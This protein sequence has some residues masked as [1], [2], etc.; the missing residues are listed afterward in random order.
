MYLL[1]FIRLCA[2]LE[3]R[4]ILIGIWH[5]KLQTLE[6]FC[7]SSFMNIFFKF[8]FDRFFWKCEGFCKGCF[9]KWY[10]NDCLALEHDKEYLFSNSYQKSMREVTAQ[11][12]KYRIKYIILWMKH[13]TFHINVS[14]EDKTF[15]LLKIC[16]MDDRFKD[17]PHCNNNFLNFRYHASIIKFQII[18]WI[19]SKPNFH[20]L[21]Q[22]NIYLLNLFLKG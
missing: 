13:I 8:Y 10:A 22:G 2:S 11:K 1:F 7:P 20:T 4:N 9:D 6:S 19:I 5:L 21:V 18:V 3:P 14:A 17:R 15:T 16:V 12:T